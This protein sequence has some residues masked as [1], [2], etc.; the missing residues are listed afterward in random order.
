[1]AIAAGVRLGCYEIVVPLGAGG[2][3]EVWRAR[4]TRLNR[5]VA[6]KV[7]PASFANDPQCMQRFEREAQMLAA[8]HH[9]NIATIFSIEQGALI[10]ELVDGPTL[11]DRISQGPL[12]VEEAIAIA[13]Q[14]AEGLEA[15]HERGVIH[16][17][18]KPANVKLTASGTVKLLDFGLAKSANEIAAAASGASP[19]IFPTVAMTQVGVILGTAAYMS[20]EQARSKPVDRRAD[21][22]A[23]GCV[24]FEML[25]GRQLFS[26]ETVTDTLASV[27]KDTPD[28]TAL[29]AATPPHVRRLLERCLRK[30][31][32]TRLGDIGEARVALDEAAAEPL[33]VP[34]AAPAARKPWWLWAAVSVLSIAL[35]ALAA[36][37]F[38]EVPP[39]APATIRFEIP[40]A[41]HFAAGRFLSVSPD[42][43]WIAWPDDDGLYLRSI[44][45]FEARSFPGAKVDGYMFWSPDSR[46]IGFLAGRKLR[47]MPAT[48]GPVQEICDVGGIVLGVAWS[49]DQQLII[50]GSARG[51]MRVPASG[52]P[53]EPVAKPADDQTAYT[54]PVLLPGSRKL[55]YSVASVGLQTRTVRVADLTADWKLRND[56]PIVQADTGA[57][58]FLDAGGRGHLL[59]LRGGSLVAQSF[60]AITATLT[61]EPVVIAESVGVYLTRG[62][63]AASLNGLIAY[64]ASDGESLQTEIVDRS[65][66]GTR[67]S[68]PE[69]QIVDL[70]V[71]PDGR[72]IAASVR[73]RDA[74]SIWA[75]DPV[76]GA[77]TRITFDDAPASRAVWSPDGNRIAYSV[78]ARGG[79]WVKPSS[80]AGEP[81]QIHSGHALPWSWSQDGK[82]LLFGA[83]QGG[84]Q[85]A[86]LPL[87]GGGKPQPYLSSRFTLTQA[88]FSPDD[89]WIAYVSNESGAAEI[90]VQPYPATSERI[91]ISTSGGVQPRWRRDG[92]EIFYIEPGSGKLMS[93]EVRPGRTLD[94]G[95]PQMLFDSRITS[96]IEGTSARYDVT[97]DGKRFYM[98][99]MPQTQS[100]SPIRVIANWQLGR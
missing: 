14:M 26:G 97:P 5:D 22:W 100:T 16:R 74:T 7:L 15:A 43:R 51:L 95:T 55:L 9:P 33:P 37:H 63:F 68:V 50:G 29:P 78:A 99:R 86:V 32:R 81:Q 6:V 70:S 8:L 93:V 66:A 11:A 57:Q 71:S 65:G 88:Q 1:M 60:D 56:R 18:L 75:L 35:I 19:T 58:Y 77:H 36:L 17:D 47:R 67:V 59:F 54:W 41:A 87:D 89:R 45:G 91:R 30:D 84:N 10:M 42:G 20:P 34:T 39:A 82:L 73:T 62:F 52:G 64:R 83:G 27:V 4:D 46:H 61:G 3:G 72:R 38:R 80:G 12:P 79:I 53:P 24:L 48:G 28:F 25:T 2:M 96:F 23:F 31:P 49:A 85:L 92:R 21:I 90:Y 40:V 98:A 94:P 13:R 44:D 76:R 69:G